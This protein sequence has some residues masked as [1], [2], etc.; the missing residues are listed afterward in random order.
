VQS[1]T[2]CVTEVEKYA[3][4]A[5]KPGGYAEKGFFSDQ[6]QAGGGPAGE[7][8]GL[9]FLSNRP[10]WKCSV[11]NVSCTSKETLMGH[12]HGTKHRR[13][14][15]AALAAKEQVNN[16]CGQEANEGRGAGAIEAPHTKEDPQEN[17]NH[18]DE[19]PGKKDK[20]R[21]EASGSGS[22]EEAEPREKTIKKK[23]KKKEAKKEAEKDAKPEKKI[24]WRRLAAAALEG[25]GGAMKLK[26]LRVAVLQAARVGEDRSDDL[27][28]VLEKSS[29]F[30][31][32]G[33]GVRLKAE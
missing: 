17:G 23:K 21:K 4:G 32:A 3:L 30:E 29:S 20:K 28:A 19:G 7:A 25:A 10:P 6:Q 12:A 5:T 1:H 8:A 27:M 15:R 13:R 11:C 22:D 14:V 2:Q 9:E 24:K 18:V 16:G 26:K 31:V 33:K